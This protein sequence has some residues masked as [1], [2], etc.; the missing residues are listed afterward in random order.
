MATRGVFSKLRLGRYATKLRQ[1]VLSGFEQETTQFW[2]HGLALLIVMT[3][4]GITLLIAPLLQDTPAA[5]FYVA[6]MIIS[7]FGGFGP[8]LF[9]TLLS[10]IFLKY[11][12]LEPF[13]SFSAIDPKTVVQSGVFAIAS[14]LISYLNESRLNAKRRAEA[15]FKAWRNSESQFTHITESN[16]IGIFSANFKGSITSANDAF[17]QMIGYTRE[18]LLAGRI[19]WDTMTPPEYQQVSQRSQHEL[20]TVGFC[21]PFEKEYIRKDGSRVPILLGSVLRDDQ[22]VIGFVLNRSESKRNEAERQQAEAALRESEERLRLALTAANQG[23]Y[24]LNVQTGEAIVNAEYARMLGYELDEFQE[25]NAKWRDRLHPDDL[26]VT[27]QAYEDYIA[28]KRNLYRVEFRQRTKSGDWKWILSIGKIVA[29][30]SHGNPLRMLGTHTDITDSKEREAERRRVEVALRERK[31]RLDLATKAAN[32]GI[33]EWNIQTDQAVWENSRMYE[34]FGR[35]LADGALSKTELINTAVHPD[36][37]E[38]LELK[39]TESMVQGSAYQAVY[40]ICRHDNGQWRWIEANGQVEFA[41]DGM[42]LRLVGILNDITDRKHAEQDLQTAEERLRLALNAAR[43]VVWDWD[44]LANRVVCS[45]NSEEVWGTQI[46]TVDDFL[47]AVHPDDRAPVA[48][49]IGDAQQEGMFQCEYRV[50]A[51]DQTVRWL[52]SRGRTYFNAQ[53]QAERMIGVSLDVSK[54]VQIEAERDLLL[55]Q[56]QAARGEAERANRIKDEFLAVLSHELRSPLNPILG[57]TK[58]LRSQKFSPEKAAQALATIERN[59]KLQAQLIEDLLDVSRIL[60]GKMLVNVSSVNLATTIKA[61]IETVR[62]AA[63]AKNIQIHATLNDD[64]S[65]EN[66]VAGDAARLQQIVWNLL[67]NAVKFT[68]QDGRIE[69]RLDRRDG[70][71]QIQVQDTGKGISPDFLPYVFDYFRQEDGATTRKFG[72]LGLGLA[73]VQHLTEQHGGTVS[74][75]SAGDGQG[76]TFTIRLPLQTLP[77]ETASEPPPT[78]STADLR[79]L[80]ILVVDDEADMCNLMETILEAYG[81][82][83]K[84]AASGMAALTILEQWKPDLLIS[85]IGMPEMDGYMLMRQIRRLE[86][87]QRESLSAEH[88]GSNRAIAKQANLPAIALTAYAGEFNQHQAFNA[89]FQQ[90]L[91]KPIEP[92]RLV[93]AIA[94]LVKTRQNCS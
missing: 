4:L 5:L 21:T 37:R 87:V 55:R 62:L 16:I 57:W 18:D 93:N 61:A 29:W 35:T 92:E 63:E 14:I 3:A 75:E 39:L 6:V 52:H 45:E 32:L 72:G 78:T 49:A 34:I 7:W 28:N 80:K 60:Q 71:A 53:G 54:R 86:A 12:F 51:P 73:L 38:S 59:A 25:T 46:G 36:D 27:A 40:R 85:D 66:I 84:V 26:A 23:L 50:I 82:E 20:R 2:Y 79:D 17:L 81:I 19:R 31:Q 89:G 74:A 88:P 24:D 11:F 56:E 91:A 83:V 47:T 15:N 44:L 42:P 43:M 22:T 33:F 69:V 10:T 13:H 64:G 67:T 70:F 68:P 77:C 65:H 9:A 90:H 76:A 30:D 58:L 48:Q 1:F 8:G 41:A 94:S